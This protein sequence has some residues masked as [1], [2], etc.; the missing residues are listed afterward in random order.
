M[1]LNI[2][3]TKGRGRWGGEEAGKELKVKV[4]ERTK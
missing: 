1:A 4:T 3:K 2:S